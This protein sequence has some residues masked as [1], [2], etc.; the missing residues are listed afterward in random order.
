MIEVKKEGI[1]L[2]KT[3]F[4][5]ESEGVF[6]PAVI[7]ANGIIRMFY[8]AVAKNN[9]SSIGYCELSSPTSISKRNE[10]PVLFPQ[11]EYEIRG[12]E[13]PR[14]VKIDNLFYITYCAYCGHNA[15]GALA[16]SH[17]LIHWKK[18]GVIVPQIGYAEFKHLA[19]S[20]GPIHE[21][22]ARFNYDINAHDTIEQKVLI[23]NKDC[24]LFPRKVNGK[25]C[26][27]QRIKPDIQ[28]VIG[29]DNL[30]EMTHEYWQNYLLHFSES[31]L[32]SPKYKHEAS[33]IGGGCPPIETSKGWLIIYHGVQDSV[34]GYIYSACAALLNLDC[35]M[36]EIARLPYPLFGPELNWEKTGTVSNICFPTG[37]IE[38]NERLFI[39]YGAADERIAV[40]SVNTND[41]I[42]ELLLHTINKSST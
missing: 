10:I 31:I 17:D 6:N 15:L 7:R 3:A 24:I 14:I 22:Y 4:G 41:L 28:I 36:Q 38:E 37:A 16:V 27:L 13:D 25:Y 18:L 33:Y 42:Q 5:F 12:M 21:K 40:A 39:Y 20:H 1:I 35:P 34:D 8:R 19:E 11:F 30:E 29:I 2:E 23:W 26:L 9:Y 32:L